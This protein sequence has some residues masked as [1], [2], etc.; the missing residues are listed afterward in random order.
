MSH[1]L[2]STVLH[3]MRT[4][5]VS[6]LPE[7]IKACLNALTDQDIWWRPN[8]NANSI[9]NLV[10]HVCGSTRLFL[11]HGIGATGYER[12]RPAE[13]AERRVI[14]REDLIRALDETVAEVD[15]I[16]GGLDPARLMETTE[17]TGKTTTFVQILL[18]VA[19]HVAAHT[20][21]IVYATK[22]VKEGAIDELWMKT[23]RAT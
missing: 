1:T 12:D 5:L 18:H 17:R 20:G 15:R 6:D 7:Q 2:D 14:R 23:R 22:L 8:E 3:V 4:R 9:G 21:Q 16:L 11:G 10:L 19:L 13:F